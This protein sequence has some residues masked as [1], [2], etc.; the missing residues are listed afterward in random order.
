[1]TDDFDEDAWDRELRQH[2]NK[3]DEAFAEDAHSPIPPDEREGF[4]GLDYYPPAPEYR[5]TATV[6]VHD[7]PEPMEFDVSS[8]APQRYL[9]VLTLRFG[10]E[11]TET[12]LS[13]YQQEGD[14]GQYFLPFRDDTSGDT[15]YGAGRYMDLHADRALEDGDEIILDFNLAYSPF[16][17]YSDAYACPL[18]PVENH[19]DVRIEAGERAD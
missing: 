19:L 18:P 5:V 4:T 16:C 15:T 12:S 7:D 1:M 14:E 3:K 6:E 9:R 10:V 17:A 8:G 13:A 11:G 2:R